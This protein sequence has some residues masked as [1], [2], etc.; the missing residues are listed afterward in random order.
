[1]N[2]KE[3]YN[4]CRKYDFS[5]IDICSK[6]E[7]IKIFVCHIKGIDYCRYYLV[8]DELELTNEEAKTFFEYMDKL[9]YDRVPI[10]Y[11]THEVDIY[12]EKYMVN[13]SVLIPRQDTETLI[14]KAVEYINRENL[15]TGLDLCSGS[16][17]IGISVSNNSN[18]STMHFIDIS[19]DALEITKKNIEKN[20]V[21]KSTLC[22][23]SNLFENIMTSGYKYDI[24]MS[25]P[26]YIPT[27]DIEKLSEYVKKEPLI[28][29]DGLETGLFFYEKII[30]KARDFLNDNGYIIFEIGYDQ[31]DSLVNIFS[32]YPEYEIIE[33]VK[34]LNSNDRVIICRFHKI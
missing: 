10:Q 28:A 11:I 16:G 8:K 17:V 1:M 9:I 7:A 18:I 26:P 21:Q 29:L 25:N 34:D 33:K 5:N 6:E 4:I 13:E 24:I 12:N 27:K 14:E 19:K 3:I 15:K 30:D 32:N 22:I 2:L 23:N 20:N 31:M